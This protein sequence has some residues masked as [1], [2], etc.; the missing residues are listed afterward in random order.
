MTPPDLDDEASD[1]AAETGY[2]PVQDY[3]AAYAQRLE[4]AVWVLT[5]A[6]RIPQPRVERR[7]DG[8]WVLDASGRFDQM[9]WAEFVTQVLAGAAA[10]FGGVEAILRGRSRSWA[11][12]GVRQLLNSKVGH[13]ESGLFAHR[14]WP[15]ATTLYVNELIRDYVEEVWTAYADARTEICWRGEVGRV[16]ADRAE[17]L[18]FLDD[19]QER[20]EAQRK[21]EWTAYGEALKARIEA[22][23]AAVPGL[24]V[25]VSVSIDIESHHARYP[26]PSIGATLEDRLVAAALLDTPTPADLPGTPL[27]RLEQRSRVGDM[28][29]R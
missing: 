10:N 3:R 26:D 18:G 23:A 29:L 20:L 16:E 28:G 11:A 14:T 5:D 15:V 2:D 24:A 21:A 7:A 19:L 8:S 13:D 12:A 25:P 1:F 17:C 6:A 9:D 22:T 4:E 27:E